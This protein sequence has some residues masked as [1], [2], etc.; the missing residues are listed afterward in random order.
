MLKFRK[1][2]RLKIVLLFTVGI[3]LLNSP[4]YGIDLS[5]DACLRSPLS[6]SQKQD[7]LGEGLERVE[8]SI[9]GPS[10]ERDFIS[11]LNIV[12]E[13]ED[14]GLFGDVASS[15]QTWIKSVSVTEFENIL[16][17]IARKRVTVADLTGEIGIKF[18]A[19]G[20]NK[21]VYRVI[22]YRKDNGHFTFAIALKK[23]TETGRI[24]QN[25]IEG[26]RWLSTKKRRK[27]ELVPVFGTFLQSKNGKKIYLEEFIEGETVG[28]L[29]QQR[30]LTLDI[31]KQILKTLV[32]IGIMLGNNFPMDVNGD[33]FI[34]RSGNKIVMVDIGNRR[35]SLPQAIKYGYY[36]TMI[37]FLFL[38]FMHYAEPKDNAFIIQGFLEGMNSMET[39]LQR[40]R[41][42]V[43]RKRKTMMQAKEEILKF[44][45]E[46][47]VY[48]SNMDSIQ[49]EHFI[50]Q[51][52]LSGNPYLYT[53]FQ[54]NTMDEGAKREFINDLLIKIE[55][56]LRE[57]VSSRASP[58]VVGI[59]FEND[60]SLLNHVISIH[61]ERL[62][63]TI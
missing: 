16:S 32:G 57:T 50:R 59:T 49:K 4:L 51:K 46:S 48:L 14:N 37:E 26:L 30:K 58:T 17:S 53:Y 42:L 1:D 43:V 28:K 7:R 31:K 27:L 8:K 15:I 45:A 61:T 38:I 62:R 6:T 25:E 41:I 2:Y 54:R 20:S 55:K 5:K 12:F 24:Q 23:E 9:V 34:N 63:E 10:S 47:L 33:N 39:F 35:F 36:D 19:K 3:F 22:F 52:L 13:E 18:H 60:P 44:F 29:K 56:A 11:R 21:D 40:N